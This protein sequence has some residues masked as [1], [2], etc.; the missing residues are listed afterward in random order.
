MTI[1][2]KSWKESLR[3]AVIIYALTL[4]S[5]V[6]IDFLDV[7]AKREYTAAS[8]VILR[9]VLVL[10]FT[11]VGCITKHKREAYLPRVALIV[12]L[13]LLSNVALGYTTFENW[14]FSVPVIAMSMLIGGALS[15]IF[16]RNAPASPKTEAGGSN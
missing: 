1:D 7:I 13:I 11:I 15:Y 14:V 5:A 2:W 4:L 9:I 8:R 16:V 12:W 6:I 10:G 3:D